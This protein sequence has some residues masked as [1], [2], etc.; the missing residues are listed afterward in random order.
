MPVHTVPTPVPAAAVDRLFVTIDPVVSDQYKTNIVSFFV[1]ESQ[2]VICSFGTHVTRTNQ[3]LC[4]VVLQ[5]VCELRQVP[6]FQ[7]SQ[8]IAIVFSNFAR[9][10]RLLGD[11]LRQLPN[12]TVLTREQGRVGALVTNR[13]IESAL[14]VLPTQ[15]AV[16][17]SPYFVA[18]TDDT[19]DLT[20][21]EINAASLRAQFAHKVKEAC[22]APDNNFVIDLD[23][24]LLVSY[25][26]GIYLYRQYKETPHYWAVGAPTVAA[27]S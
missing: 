14:R 17:Y 4:L 26:M 8:L 7:A 5:H 11:R 20:L 21:H 1:H 13:A 24:G 27:L 3:E 9:E 6:M 22:K 23:D 10:A 19:T 25:I 2:P 16:V 18:T 12:T 15:A